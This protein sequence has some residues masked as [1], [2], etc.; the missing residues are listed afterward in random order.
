M[1][2][3]TL[4]IQV[5]TYLAAA[6]VALLGGFAGHA[7]AVNF[8]DIPPELAASITS[9]C[10]LGPGYFLHHYLDGLLKS[11]NSQLAALQM[12]ADV[13]MAERSQMSPP[14]NIVRLQSD[15]TGGTIIRTT[16]E[17]QSAQ[18]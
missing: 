17:P 11:H 13:S 12:N 5:I 9:V 2:I 8:T 6:L 16:V 7:I 18:T 3:S 15:L 1:N 4:W 10:A 14:A